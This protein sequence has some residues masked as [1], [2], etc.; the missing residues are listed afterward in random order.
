LEEGPFEEID[1]EDGKGEGRFGQNTEVRVGKLRGA[2]R[3]EARADEEVGEDG[4]EED[5]KAYYSGGPGELFSG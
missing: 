1:T 4:G 2:R 3:G 5:D